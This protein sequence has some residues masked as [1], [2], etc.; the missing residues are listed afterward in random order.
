MINYTYNYISYD[1]LKRII[2]CN[3]CVFVCFL[4]S[5]THLNNFI[6]CYLYTCIPKLD[7]KL[8]YVVSLKSLF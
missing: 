7:L 2:Y 8:F 3:Q 4:Y 1:T 5:L 6:F